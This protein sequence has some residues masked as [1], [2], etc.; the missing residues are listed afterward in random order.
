MLKG[1][2]SF[3]G[4]YRILHLSWFAFFLTFVCWFNFAPF[5]TTIGRELGLADSQIKTLGICNIA[6]TI[7]ARIII[8]ML[9]DRFGPRLTYTA[10]L[11]YA[12]LPCLVTATAHD[13][14]QLV[15]G[16]LLMGIV[17][18]GFVVGI[19]MVSEWFPPKEIGSAQ[20]IYGGWGNFGAAASEFG[21]PI[22]A[23]GTA[24]LSGNATNWRLAIALIGVVTALY[25]MLYYNNVQNTPADKI[26]KKPKKNGAMEVT[27]VNSFLALCLSN[28]GLILALALLAWRLA[29]PKIH[30]LSEPQMYAVWLFLA[31]LYTFQTYKAYVVNR[32]MLIGKKIYSPSERY[33]FRQV[34]L[35]EFAYV[36][37]FGSELAV[38]SMLP[39]FFEKTF[40]LDHVTAALI[41]SSYPL[42]N[43]MSRPS[44][45]YISDRLGSRK[46]TLTVITAIIGCSYLMMSQIRSNW[47]ITAAIAT[48]IFC[49][50]F[51]QAG[52]GATFGMAPLIKKEITGQIAGNV[53]AYGNFGGV[54]FLTVFSLTNPTTLFETM[55]VAALICASLCAF[56]L[57]EPRG[58]FAAEEEELSETITQSP[59]MLA[60]E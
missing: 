1:L 12:V 24:F 48:C 25:A 34:A 41:A 30:F 46:W 52:C 27:S 28:L 17:G 23:A 58:S 49:A 16:R 36:T 43:F 29:Q 21:L 8:G 2:L 40:T 22:I 42:L 7:P 45:G 32:E 54:V 33:Q 59:A 26:Y 31:A 53:G 19:R 50:Y 20:G 10:L 37:N 11:I 51:V 35:L 39:A 14:N 15:W 47:A 44:G 55:G 9:L 4:R 3:H 38:V 6:L 60:E 56:F 13:F 57:K 5:A 18:S